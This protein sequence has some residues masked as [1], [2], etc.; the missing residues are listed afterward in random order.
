MGAHCHLPVSP[1]PRLWLL[2]RESRQEL[3]QAQR[4]VAGSSHQREAP[5]ALLPVQCRRTIGFRPHRGPSCSPSCS[6]LALSYLAH[7]T[8]PGFVA[9]GRDLPG[10]RAT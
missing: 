3:P 6:R 5:G 8:V 4:K 10:R 9:E 1:L 7:L 2:S